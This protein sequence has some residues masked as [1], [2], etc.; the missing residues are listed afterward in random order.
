M[1]EENKVKM[2]KLLE[3]MQEKKEEI[4]DEIV[5]GAYF[6]DVK[7]VD[8]LKEEIAKMEEEYKQLEAIPTKERI[9]EDIRLLE[10]KLEE[11]NDEFSQYLR[12]L[13]YE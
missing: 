8:Q 10:G 11:I 7:K 4:N 3:A 6:Y 5:P 1:E 13:F 9:E 2:G 12:S